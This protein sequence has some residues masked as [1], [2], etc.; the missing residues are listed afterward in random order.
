MRRCQI[1]RRGKDTYYID[2]FDEGLYRIFEDLARYGYSIV[3]NTDKLR[4]FGVELRVFRLSGILRMGWDKLFYTTIVALDP[5][6][7]LRKDGKKPERF[8]L[9]RY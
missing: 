9:K 5:S 2:V 1:L 6:Y 8:I 4:V 3:Q 7:T